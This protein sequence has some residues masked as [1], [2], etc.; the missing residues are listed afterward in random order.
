MSGYRYRAC[1]QLSAAR[2][3]A[4]YIIIL[5]TRLRNYVR[6]HYLRASRRRCA[7]LGRGA[8]VNRAGRQPR[9]CCWIVLQC[10]G[11]LERAS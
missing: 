3:T 5:Q 1:A 6:A 11:V 7:C 10:V 9:G 4:V 2:G 8:P